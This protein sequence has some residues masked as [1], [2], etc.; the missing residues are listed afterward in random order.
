MY[1]VGA[2]DD[3]Q[4][5]RMISARGI[6][7]GDERDEVLQCSWRGAYLW[8]SYDCMDYNGGVML[9]HP[10]LAEP[11]SRSFSGKAKRWAEF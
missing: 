11:H 7:G 5:Q 1:R 2:L 4:P 10:A 6:V 3:R 9:I 8:A